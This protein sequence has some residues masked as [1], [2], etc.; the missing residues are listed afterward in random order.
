MNMSLILSALREQLS[1]LSKKEQ[2]LAEYIL[3][4]PHRMI[5][6]G[7]V[8]LAEASGTST[9]T[10]SR[11]CRTLQFAGY[12][13]LRMKLTADL[14]GQKRPLQSFQDIVEDRPLSD[15]VAAI[16]A[17]NIRAIAE[18][19]RLLD[20]SQLDRTIEALLSARQIAIFGMATSGVVAQDFMQKLVRIGKL[21]TAFA[22]PHMQITS[23]ASLG[24]RDVAIAISYSGETPETIDAL[25]CAK[26]QG[27][28]TISMTQY[29]SSTLSRL[30]DIPLFVSPLEE[31]IK[32]G[33]MAS[34]LALLHIIDILF[35]GMLSRRF[36]DYV[37]ILEQS[38]QLVR[39]YRKQHT[40][41]RKK[42]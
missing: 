26:E 37:P 23:A 11:F 17:N 29:S 1:H 7:I 32:R 6:M 10:I 38:H 21:A 8:E 12:P 13:D 24:E 30:A 42:S 3:N 16:E 39:K 5:Q 40:G 4:E 41:N 34:R 9:S 15:I 31:G 28:L 35:T 36:N 27:C 25:K 14:A 22:D 20:L 33:D 2:I 18:T 19:T